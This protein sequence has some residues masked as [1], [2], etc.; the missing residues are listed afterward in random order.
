MPKKKKSK[1]KHN[2][3]YVQ[4]GE[5]IW[6]KDHYYISC[7][8]CGL[9]HHVI[10]DKEIKRDK[11]KSVTIPND[12]WLSLKAYRDNYTTEREREKLGVTLKKR[13]R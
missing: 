2:V 1:F 12:N 11:N 9:T 4:D 7:C 13:R 3:S 10:V 6:V 8:D 5:S